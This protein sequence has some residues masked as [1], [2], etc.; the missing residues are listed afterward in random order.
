MAL[1]AGAKL[2]F[3]VEASE[4]NPKVGR[5]KFEVADDAAGPYTAVPEFEYPYDE[6]TFVIEGSYKI[7]DYNLCDDEDERWMAEAPDAIA[8]AAESPP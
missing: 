2:P 1:E 5:I 8:E 3:K 6:T 4:A 7:K